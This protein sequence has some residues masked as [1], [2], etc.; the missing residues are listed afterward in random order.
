MATASPGPGAPATVFTW[1]NVRG[2]GALGHDATDGEGDCPLPV[3]V[4]DGL[5]PSIV[6]V[7]AGPNA[8]AAVSDGGELFTWGTGLKLGHGPDA[9][10]VA[11]PRRVNGGGLAAHQVLT[12]SLGDDHAGCTTASGAAFTWGSTKRGQCGN[13]PEGTA[14]VLS[15]TLVLGL[16]PAGA[17]SLV[18]SNRYTAVLDSEALYTRSARA[19]TGSSAMAT[20]M[21]SRLRRGSRS[22]TTCTPVRLEAAAAAAAA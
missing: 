12:V 3:P 17:V 21:T 10:C 15:P 1:G 9:G 16:G 2:S 18:A 6:A 11:R 20:R 4:T 7:A 13:A 5:P 8:T 19:P 22:R 14:Q